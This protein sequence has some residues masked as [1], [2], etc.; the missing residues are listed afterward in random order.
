MFGKKSKFQIKT[1]VRI[2]KQAV[3]P[4]TRTKS[5]GASKAASGSTS[6]GG[7][8]VSSSSGAHYNNRPQASRNGSTGQVK[9]L[10][11]TSTST[12]PERRRTPSSS[13]LIPSRK[14]RTPG[15]RS[16]A[17]I[18]SPA[19]SDSEP[20]SDDDDWRERLDPTKRRKRTHTSTET[21]PNRRVRHPKIWN[22]QGQG[23]AAHEEG[24]T[25]GIVHSADVASLSDKCQPVMSLGPDDVGVS[26]RYPGA[27]LLER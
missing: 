12:T 1:E 17:A 20:G 24:E 10:Q 23:D 8:R 2:V 26:L 16:P 3:D 7:V 25:L 4:A 5:A 18:A 27:N 13:L 22:G 6:N 21:D 19:L 9:R 11:A 15:S 14:R